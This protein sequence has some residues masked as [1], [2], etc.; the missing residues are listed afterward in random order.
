M[1]RLLV[2]LCVSALVFAVASPLMAGGIDN[3]HNFS[4]EYIRTLNR[5]AAT[6]SADAVVYN[7]AGVA[8]MED[9]LYAN[10]SLQYAFKDYSNT[11][12]G[13]EYESDEPDIV[14]GLFALYRKDQW[15]GYAAFTIPCGGGSVD[16]ADG[17]ATTY[18]LALQTILLS[19]GLLDNIVSQELEGESFYYGFTVGGAYAVN[20]MLSVSLGARYVDARREFE[21]SA[22]LNNTLAPEASLTTYGVK[23]EE[24]GDGWGGILGVNITPTEKWNIGIRYETQTSVDLETDEKRDALGIVTDGAERNRDLPALLGIGVSH[25][26]TPNLR[27]EVNLTYYFNEDADWDDDPL[28]MGD[29]TEKDN[30]YDVGIALEYM[31]MPELKASVGYMYTNV[32]IDPDDMSRAAPE[33]DAHTIAGGVAYEAMPGLNL[34][35]GILKT[36][37]QDETTS[38]APPAFPNGIELEKD[39]IILSLGVQ[40]KFW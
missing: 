22:T 10:L 32:G 3:K 7:P 19:G 28:T 24:T 27:T 6:D 13:V 15:A 21:G 8:R 37:Y 38:A 40:Y 26:C 12:N 35:F 31:F 29:E 30:G 4:A 39:V 14:P 20:D 23:Y 9:G 16:Y 2:F 25:Q 34:N 5:N 1:K 17:M 11:F 33:L 36:F 18:G